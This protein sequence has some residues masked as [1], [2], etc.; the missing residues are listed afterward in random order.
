[1]PSVRSWLDS[2]KTLAISKGKVL[3]C[4]EGGQHYVGTG[5]S[6]NNEAL[7]DLLVDFNRDWR[8]RNLYRYTYM[9]DVNSRGVQLFSAFTLSSQWGK[10][11][12]WG[13]MEWLQQSIGQNSY[14]AVKE[15][16]IRDWKTN[17]P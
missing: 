12:S 7:T 11:G 10:W 6:E 15:W 1:M 3:V 17:N 5:G 16:G 9:G 8:M 2:H 13:S 14:E 4:Y